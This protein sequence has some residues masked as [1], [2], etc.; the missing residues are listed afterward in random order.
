MKPFSIIY[1]V[2]QELRYAL[3]SSCGNLINVIF[4]ELIVIWN[5][6]FL[7]HF[8]ERRFDN[9]VCDALGD[10]SAWSRSESLM[11]PIN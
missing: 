5:N 9:N 2:S 7:V 11:F 3:L 8:Q 1:S 6:T 4:H 10:K